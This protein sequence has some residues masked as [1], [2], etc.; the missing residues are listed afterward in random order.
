MTIDYAIE[1]TTYLFFGQRKVSVAAVSFKS[2]EFTFRT[3]A[4][5]LFVTTT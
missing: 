5:I 2:V 4:R 1:S 3:A